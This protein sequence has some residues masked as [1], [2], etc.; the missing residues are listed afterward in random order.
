MLKKI[1]AMAIIVSWELDTPQSFQNF[2]SE[3]RANR[4]KFF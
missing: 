3:R 1:F 2:I 4:S